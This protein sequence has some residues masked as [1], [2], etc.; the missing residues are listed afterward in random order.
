MRVILLFLVTA[1]VANA[2][3]ESCEAQLKAAQADVVLKQ[4]ALSKLA[5]AG[6][7]SNHESEELRKIINEHTDEITRM[8][9]QAA[10][11]EKKYENVKK[12]AGDEIQALKKKLKEYET[13]INR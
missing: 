1:L 8:R 6:T 12:S 2:K 9:I 7:M 10:D 5:S 4:K 11:G 3:D 13:K